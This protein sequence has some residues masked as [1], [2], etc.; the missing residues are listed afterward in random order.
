MPIYLYFVGAVFY[1]LHFRVGFLFRSGRCWA[2]LILS[3]IAALGAPILCGGIAMGSSPPYAALRIIF[4]YSTL[5][6]ELFGTSDAMTMLFIIVNPFA[7]FLFYGAGCAIACHK[8]K[9]G[10][11]MLALAAW[12]GLFVLGAFLV[13]PAKN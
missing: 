13:Q 2:W 3:A 8:R 4:P 7:Q 1:I 10:W 12:H 9:L 5:L 6:W 11:F